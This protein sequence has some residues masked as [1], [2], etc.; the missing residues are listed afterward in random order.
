MQALDQDTEFFEVADLEADHEMTEDREDLLIDACFYFILPDYYTLTD[1]EFI[2]RLN[3]EVTV[4]P[5]CAEADF[6]T[7][8]GLSIFQKRVR[9]D[10][11]EGQI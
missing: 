11:Q 10:L 3:E 6:M 4:V 1:V 7:H 5:I 2:K 8:K 9:S